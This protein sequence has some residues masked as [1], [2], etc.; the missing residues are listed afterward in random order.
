MAAKI[1]LSNSLFGR[2]F[3]TFLLFIT[4]AFAS[5]AQLV[6]T[7]NQTI[8]TNQT[9]TG[10]S[11]ITTGTVTVSGGT[12]TF[13]GNLTIGTGGALVIQNSA[14]VIVNGTVT[15]G[16]SSTGSLTVQNGGLLT[17]N[18][19]SSGGTAAINMN[20]TSATGLDIQTGG[21]VIVNAGSTT[22]LGMYETSS[23][24][25]NV[26]GS[27]QIRGG[28]F[29]M[30]NTAKL[31]YSGSG[32][33]TIIGNPNATAAYFSNSTVL[34]VGPN[35]N[36]YISGDTKN[37][38]N[39]NF[40]INGNVSINGNYQSGNNTANVTGTGTLST[41]GSLDSDGNQGTVFGQHY[42]CAT[43]P[44]AGN[45]V[46][47]SNNTT[48][49]NGGTVAMTGVAYS[50]ATYQWQVS[51]SNSPFAFSSI[52]GATAQNYT[53]TGSSTTQYTYYRRQYTL[54]GQTYNSNTLTITSSYWVTSS[55]VPAIGGLSSVCS[56]STITL[57]NSLSGGTWSS[58]NTSVATVS[59]SGV[60]TGISAGTAV[61][62]YAGPSSGCYT[63]ATKTITVLETASTTTLSS[64][65]SYTVP[66]N[67]KSVSI[68]VWGAGGGGSKGYTGLKGTGGGGGGYALQIVSVNP[69][70]VIAVTVG[71]G[72]LGATVSGNGND[73]G[74]SSAT[75][76]S[77]TISATGGLAGV[78]T[79]TPS[80]TGGTGGS[81]TNGAYNYS[82]GGGANITLPAQ[83]TPG[84]G[85]GGS[86]GTSS[87]GNNAGNTTPGSGTPGATAVAGGGAGGSGSSATNGDGSAG[88]FPGGGGG[89]NAGTG[90][91]GNGA[92]GV[93]II[94]A[95]YTK[96]TY[97]AASFCKSTTSASPT[98][99]GVTG[100]TFSSTTGLT[101]NS[102]T[103]IINPSTSTAGTYTVSYSNTCG[104]IS[105]TVVGILA[106]PTATA[107]GSQSI[108]QSATA[109][110]SGATSS[111]GT[112]AWTENG[113]G[114]ITS[115]AT[116][117]TPTYT[118]VAADAGTT[119]TLTMTVSNAAC[120]ATATYSVTVT[121]CPKT[122]TGLTTTDWNTST[123][124]SPTGVPASSD[125]V[126][127]PSVTN[128]PVIASGVT[129]NAK[130]VT[131][132]SSSS[133]TINSTGILNTYGSVTNNGTFTANSG[134]TLAFKGSSAQTITGV[135]V[136]Y[137]V[138]I[139]NTSGGVAI[140]SALT[141]KGSISLLNG[142]LTTNS[143]LT[144][145]FDNGGNIAYSS[146][147]LGSISGNV[148]GTRSL[149]ARTHYIAAPFSGV[150]SAQVQATTPLY[151]N[152]YWK[153]Y[154]KTFATQGW[155]AVMDVST[156]MPLGTGFSLSVP[157]A[158]PLAFTGTYSHTFTLTG[159]TYSNAAAGKY[160]LVGNP[161]PSTLDWSDIYGTTTAN[162]TGSIYYWSAST[163]Q[164][165]SWA[166]GV[167]AGNPTGTQ[168]IPAMQAFMVTTTGTGGNSSVSINNSART[169]L[170]NPSY[171]RVAQTDEII[172]LK[173]LTEDSAKWDDAVIRFNEMA[174]IGFDS[175]LDAYKILNASSVSIYT[176][177]DSVNYSINAL[178]ASQTSIPVSI[179]LPADGNYILTVSNTGSLSDYVLIDHKLGTENLLSGPAYKFSGLKADNAD[180]FELQLRTVTT[181]ASSTT[182]GVTNASLTS[183]LQ[184]NSS[185]KGFVI[186]TQQ[187]AN[188]DASI[189]IL[190]V[191]GR[192]IKILADKNLSNGVTYVPLDMA[193]GAYVVKVVVDG[194]VFAQLISLTK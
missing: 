113:A 172:R 154:T 190:D 37:D 184:I 165:S 162:V 50:G 120:S 98:I 128:K 174:T 81:G 182:T 59:S 1:N 3:F 144:I 64:S 118:S 77:T 43:G 74:T 93:V 4:F 28:G 68:Q 49:C 189:E 13:N 61:I 153:M 193:E 140:S 88:G 91:G 185:S 29:K 180:R 19:G 187:F 48:T 33:D 99:T 96:I 164:V 137:N 108:C 100:G 53:T 104:V 176:V 150:T 173:V 106:T 95:Y 40:A 23:S 177:A 151:V 79:N 181:A 168:Y 178:P 105:T 5:F 25:A 41:T 15:I 175:D 135:P 35:V 71:T 83:S 145:N 24:N 163:S 20:S 12:I 27:L 58:S 130:N 131:V 142:V 159:A 86:A 54:S 117:L 18:P 147:D 67:A 66:A 116:T 158:A 109:T 90:N 57:T 30:D 21:T 97:T 124:W 139:N 121:A 75:A 146:G 78:S 82:G 125:D 14:K 85:A 171:L 115:G 22:L 51:T 38:S 26:A 60:V 112:I 132:N 149:I 101:I 69:G 122:W 141:V 186:Q 8:S 169:N 52:S 11:S 119:V 92:N 56:G 63:A 179:K 166:G 9:Y 73:G 80:G 16:T 31:T 136:L 155:A 55:T 143:N 129:A 39:A 160:I 7:S 76:G 2:V 34:T 134:S 65:G 133:L 114:S 157:S 72:G 191:T 192:T 148:T 102:S 161:Y 87:N 107:G 45:N 194:N 167:G 126:I 70:D 36:L 44:C 46:I 156:S 111:N 183:G 84:G 62:T 103:G 110:V 123:N 6:A 94:T 170:Q 10:S 152:P 127:I 42:S 32:N 47:S 188:E 138:Q 17:V 89:G